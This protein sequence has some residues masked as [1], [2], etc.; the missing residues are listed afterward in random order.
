MHFTWNHFTVL[1]PRKPAAWL[2]DRAGIC[3]C[4]QSFDNLEHWRSDFIQNA[5]VDPDK[6]DS[7]PFLVLGN[8]SDLESERKVGRCPLEEAFDCSDYISGVCVCVLQ[9]PKEKALKW[10]KSKGTKVSPLKSL[11][12][13]SFYGD[14]ICMSCC[15]CMACL[16][17][18]MTLA[19]DSLLRDKRQG[20]D[21]GGVGF[22]GSC[23]TSPPASRHRE[24]RVSHDSVGANAASVLMPAVG[25]RHGGQLLPRDHLPVA[26]TS[27]EGA[28]LLLRRGGD[29]GPA[30]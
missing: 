22:L 8:K 13:A 9:V 26:A 28:E 18:H 21:A 25:C 11:V 3:R 1:T 24:G 7:F 6:A 23:S 17:L 14:D 29:E 16:L 2:T 30:G 15:L 4:V 5:N 12:L 20:R 10:C 19:A 27:E